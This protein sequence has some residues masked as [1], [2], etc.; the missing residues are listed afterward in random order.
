MGT[1]TINSKKRYLTSLTTKHRELDNKI[2]KIT[3]TASDQEIKALK[4][5]K[6]QLKEQI[7]ALE[8][9]ILT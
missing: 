1:G 3:N 9:E 5:Q 7:V 6:L 8:T 4:Q 2:V